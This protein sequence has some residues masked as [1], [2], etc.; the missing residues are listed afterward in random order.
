MATII[1][2]P[3]Q[4]SFAGNLKNIV[5]TTEARITFKLKY[6][7]EVLIESS[8]DP[9]LNDKVEIDIKKI[10]QDT[11]ISSI[12]VTSSIAVK[13]FPSFS[14][15]VDQ[16]AEFVFYAFEGGVDA[17]IA[18]TWFAGNFL[19]WQPQTSYVT[20]NQPQFLSYIA[21]AACN[22][23]VKGYFADGTNQTILFGALAANKVNTANLQY[24]SLQAKFS[25]KQPTYIDV[26]T[27]NASGQR[28]S[29]IQRF[30]LKNTTADDNCFLFKNSLGGWD[31][32][33]FTGTIKNEA[34]SDV[35]TFSQE[36]TTN[37]Y[38]VDLAEKY[39]KNTG[40]FI[41][42]K[43]RIWIAEFFKT[44][45]RYFL[46]HRG[47]FEKLTVLSST[48]NSQKSNPSSY[49]FTFSLSRST[50]YLNLPR[51]EAPEAPLQV[52]DPAGE[53]FF[54]APRL[55][56]F[57]DAE[58]VD[59]LLIPA[60]S[61]YLEAWKKFS[62]GALK[63]WIAT[64]VSTSEI[65]TSSHTHTN[66]SVLDKITSFFKKDDTGTVNDGSVFSGLRMRKEFLRKD[67]TDTAAER[68]AFSKG[69]ESP[70]ITTTEFVPGFAG[71]GFSLRLDEDG[72]A[73]LDVDELSVRQSAKFYELI[74]QQAK[75]QG[76]IVFYTA[77]SMEC[78]S[79]TEQADSYRCFFDTK[80]GQIPNE[81]AVNDQA[82]CQRFAGKYY[83][84]KVIAIGTD[85]I[86]LS[87]A[88]T[89]GAGVPEKGDII[90]QLGN[91]ADTARQAA[92]VTTVIGAD[93]PRDE[94]YEGINSYDLTGKLI[95]VVGTKDGKVGIYTTNGEFSGKVSIG[96][97]SS[98]LSGL[99]EWAAAAQDIEAAQSTAN[100]AVQS[101]ASLQS[102]IDNTLPAELSS[103]QAQIDGK[104]ESWYYDYSPTLANYPA[105]EWITDVLK[106]RH[107]GDTF[108]N[109]QEFVDSSTTPDAGKSWRFVKNGSVY[110]WTPIADSDAV[111][112]LLAA[113]KAQDTA[114]GKR[115]VFVT[116][117]TTPYEVGDLWT[118]GAAGDIMRCVNQRLSG[119][120]VAG[121]WEKAVKYT[122]DTTVN[123]LQ[124]G[125][126][127]Y[128]RNSE[129]LSLAEWNSYNTELSIVEGSLR[130][131]GSAQYVGVK[132]AFANTMD[133]QKEVTISF[134][135]KNNKSTPCS[136][137]LFPNGNGVVYIGTLPANSGWTKLSRTYIPAPVQVDKVNAN[138]THIYTEGEIDLQIKY[139]KLEYG[140][141][142]SDWS[143]A[144]ED[145]AAD[146]TAKAAAAQAAAEAYA[147]AKANLAEVTAKAY[148]DGIVTEEEA[149][150][151]ADA[152]AK[153]NAAQAAAISAAAADAT[154][155]SAAAQTAA[156][157]YA[158]AK[159]NLAE[160]TAKAYADGIV[161]DEEARA[162]ADATAKA[163]AAQAAAISAA[164][165]DATA[166]TNA[167][168]VG[169]RNYIERSKF[170][171][172]L[173]VDA[174]N[175]CNLSLLDGYV[176][177]VSFNDNYSYV[178]PKSF[179]LP[180]NEIFTLSFEYRRNHDI[181]NE[182]RITPN[183][184]GSCLNLPVDSQVWQKAQVTFKSETYS[185]GEYFTRIYFEFYDTSGNP[186][187]NTDI[188]L[189]KIKLETGNKATDWT[190]AH[191]DIA[192]DATAKAAAAQ[193]A[194]EAYALAKANL[195]ETTAK[196]YADGIV[197]EE[198]ARAIADATAKANAAQAAAISAAAADAAAR[199]NAVAIGGR[200]Y[201]ANSE[202]KTLT[203]WNAYNS[204]LSI[205]DSSL[206]IV[207][208]ASF[209]GV[210]KA[211]T[212]PL[213]AQRQVTISFFA[214]NNKSA[215]IYIQGWPN[216]NG[217]IN[218][219]SVPGN[220]GWVKLSCTFLPH[221]YQVDKVNT[222]GIHIF[223]NGDGDTD[224]QIKQ[225]KAEYGNKAS[226]WTLALED[227]QAEID[228]AKAK[229]LELEYLKTAL[230]GTTEVAGGLI[231]AR[232]M[233]LKNAL[234]QVTA[235]ISGMDSNDIFLFANDTDALNAAL[236]DMAT[237]LMRRNGTGNLGNL[238][239]TR[240]GLAYCPRLANGKLGAPIIEFRS[241]PIPPLSD[242]VASFT[243]SVNGVGGS[244][245]K[246]GGVKTGNFGYSAPITVSAYDNFSMRVQG[247]LE[248]S[249]NNAYN[250]PISDSHAAINLVLYSYAGGVYT[251]ER[252]VSSHY[253]MSEETGS[254]SDSISVDET[255]M[256]AKGTYYL[257]AEYYLNTTLSSLDS[258]QISASS[259]VMTASGA[260]GQ[261]MMIFGSNGFVRIKDGTNYTY[262]SDEMMAHRGVFDVQGV[263]GSGSVSSSGGLSNAFGKATD[264][265][266][267]STGVYIISHSIG[268]TNYGVNLTIISSNAQLN[269]VVTAKN[270]TS[271]E[272][273][274]VNASNNALSDSAFDFSM[275]ANV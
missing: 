201:F 257:R 39:S 46:S 155:K 53:L 166:K 153:A 65:G 140:N 66:K 81:W 165:A 185:A 203:G 212:T 126:R 251:Q 38:Q 195:A 80:D 245:N 103:L 124:F 36:D 240:D 248:A 163:N 161:T 188:S 178:Y 261:K 51:V 129:I 254:L 50:K 256:L 154:A 206:K 5:V 77:A 142:A 18:S 263:R 12:P 83:W 235:G 260:S 266:K 231:L 131:V 70:D 106:D 73:I 250:T 82:R 224:F 151:I 48:I 210:W 176:R 54:L 164:S 167:I 117:P 59:E 141:K 228:A 271:F 20:W 68:I 19:T 162:I 90:V 275:Y 125:G 177:A 27:E 211:Y 180:K 158:L 122:D 85:Y 97:G 33:V 221:I 144:H 89:N 202:I 225:I 79:V 175:Y 192:A 127:N 205:V 119:A 265:G 207:G 170:D 172:L 132:V 61:P 262:M 105:I 104:V 236:N 227:V 272:V 121:D 108:T 84:R 229:A 198:E 156:Q 258:A 41:S 56:E 247:L 26:W 241:T 43:H 134:F 14:F 30:V 28:L 268:H 31:S 249:I 274:I 67:V 107:I 99:S 29:Y 230:T 2:Q 204:A 7:S 93:A 11:L 74:I 64:F 109:T 217:T 22:L 219:G 138:G 193:A 157:E 17:I 143:L 57:P 226:D 72:R 37:E 9:D 234:N 182:I 60:Q 181:L 259:L 222:N 133:A 232:M 86:D 270:N 92:K 215:A 136:I 35:K 6:G 49:N 220:S 88:D 130:M 44:S 190:L 179:F 135:A 52:V 169:G 264:S 111:K 75:H 55:V 101:A 25:D 71:K 116:Q 196:A 113:S 34:S 47:Y 1:Q 8:Y 239:F 63:N 168:R 171:S 100:Q 128:I 102:F 146:A 173:D 40:Y 246:T 3:D 243:T 123:N 15:S 159:A 269:A 191:E 96:A 273:K 95:T 197:T 16:G 98:G 216:G 174:Y 32:V 186:A 120:Y 208:D 149:R 145:I 209:L 94:F 91:R 69:I 187:K 24:S 115:R 233:M 10:I 150:A 45:E 147:L 214:K 242:L 218:F 112:A 137:G 184:H 189:R 62:L 200:N 152:T 255:F 23:K 78:I 199:V 237:F 42:D 238:R 110:S 21:L 160:T 252:I 76:G 267:T 194:A 148:A 13:D 244:D 87:K 114:D 4:Y 213:D 58:F 139:V 253:I 118:Q 183:G 223:I